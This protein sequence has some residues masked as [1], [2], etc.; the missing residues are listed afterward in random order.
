MRR[1]AALA[2]IAAVPPALLAACA[3]TSPPDGNLAQQ[4]VRVVFFQEDSV[5]V[6]PTAMDVIQDA[7][8]VAKRFPNAPVRVLGFI[9]PDPVNAPTVVQALRLSRV[10]ADRVAAELVQL[11]VSRDRV[12]IRGRGTADVADAAVEARRVEIHIGPN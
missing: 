5:D 12:Q 9:A 2:A 10:R 11:G 4:P 1:R 3:P 8:Q 6:T 7:A